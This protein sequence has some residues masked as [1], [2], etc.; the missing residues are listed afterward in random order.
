[1]RSWI[2]PAA[3]ND[4]AIC[5]TASV[6]FFSLLARRV[7]DSSMLPTDATIFRVRFLADLQSE[8]LSL[9]LDETVLTRARDLVT[10]Y[11][12]RAL[13]AL[14]LASAVEIATALGDPLTFISGDTKLL[15]AAV[16][17]GFA[18]DNPYNHP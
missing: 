14:Q 3:G 17:E 5:E 6:E 11:D 2:E 16:G 4:I 1:M 9:P 12:L 13:D 7:R 8:Y 10:Q 15:T 18:T